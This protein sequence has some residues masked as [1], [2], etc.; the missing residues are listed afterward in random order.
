MFNVCFQCGSYHADKRIVPTGPS[1]VCPD[2]GYAHPFLQLPLLVV[3]G[4]SAA[5]KTAICRRLTGRVTDA[6]LLDADILWR[7]EFNQPQNDYRDFYETWLSI[8]KNIAQSGRPVVLF[9][10]GAGVSS[11]LEPCVE[12]R[13]ISHIR[14]L[15]QVCADDI[16][17]ERLKARPTWRG[18]TDSSNLDGQIAFNRWVKESSGVD[19]IDTSQQTEETTAG[20]V[21]DWIATGIK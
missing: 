13:Y 21:A 8:C 12:R 4:A 10:A 16:L 15:A 19:L 17:I 18:A 20:Q 9:N 14:T 2:C 6:V 3:S 5:G 7:P 11:N 1:A